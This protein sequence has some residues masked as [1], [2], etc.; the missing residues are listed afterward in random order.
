MAKVNTSRKQKTF[1]V[2]DMEIV[3]L[4]RGV[5]STSHDPKRN[6]ANKS[7][8]WTALIECLRDG[9]VEEFKDILRA[10]Y[11]A[12]NTT[13]ALKRTGLSKRTFYSALAPEGNPS[14]DTVMKMIAGLKQEKAS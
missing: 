4:K 11:E 7:F 14:L 5:K 13:Q 12:V 3:S 6:L 10:H 9:D 2:N 1:S 8:V